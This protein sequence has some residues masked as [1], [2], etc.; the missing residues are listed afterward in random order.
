MRDRPLIIV[1]FIASPYRSFVLFF[2][3]AHEF[4]DRRDNF[5]LNVQVSYERAIENSGSTEKRPR[6]RRAPTQPSNQL[7]KKAREKKYKK[8]FFCIFFP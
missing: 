3:S 1:V 4:S 5:H 8:F 7:K 2:F 6:V